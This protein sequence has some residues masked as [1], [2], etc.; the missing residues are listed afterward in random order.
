[1]STYDELLERRWPV[2]ES[3]R[4]LSPE[5]SAQ[6]LRAWSLEMWTCREQQQIWAALEQLAREARQR[7]EE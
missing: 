7:G 1:M 3:K 6:F 4:R 2:E 5:E